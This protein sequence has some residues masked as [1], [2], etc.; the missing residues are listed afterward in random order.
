MIPVI[1]VS[2]RSNEQVDTYL[3]AVKGT[4]YDCIF[5]PI[6]P[7]EKLEDDFIFHGLLLTGGGDVAEGDHYGLSCGDINGVNEERD[8]LEYHLIEHAL[9][10][11]IP[12]LG[13]CR[14]MQIL[15][16]FLGGKLYRDLECNGYDKHDGSLDK[17]IHHEV[18]IEP[19]TILNSLINQSSAIVNSFHHQGVAELG[20]GLKVSAYSSDGVIEAFEKENPFIF[21]LQ[22]HPERMVESDSFARSIFKKFVEKVIG[23]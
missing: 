18:K 1:V 22:W 13:I 8:E 15:N 11:R 14:G 5:R 16:V 12:I 10:K 20:N 3:K 7:G 6:F 19:S 4:G 17:P 2:G 9:T 23:Y 21:G